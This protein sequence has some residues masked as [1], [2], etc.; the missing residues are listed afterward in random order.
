[1]NAETPIVRPER[2]HVDDVIH[3]LDSGRFEQ[4]QRI[5]TVMARSPLT[6]D[7]LVA[8]VEGFGRDRKVIPLEWD[9]RLA[10]CFLVVNQAVRWG[11]DPFAVAQCCSVVHGKLMFEGKLVAAVLT[12]KL[13]H[14]LAYRWNDATGDAFGIR[15]IGTPDRLGEERI[16]DG[17]VGQWKTSG[18]N[19]PWSK[20]ADHRR[21]LV[22]RGTRDWVRLFEPA[23]LLGVYTPDE[24][25]DL[26]ERASGGAAA[27][28]SEPPR[29]VRSRAKAADA[30]L[31]LAHQP[32]TPV[33]SAAS[34][35]SAETVP[36]GNQAPA[37]AAQKP[38]AQQ[39]N[40]QTE[41][42][43]ANAREYEAV[44]VA[45]EKAA[46]EATTRQELEAAEELTAVY[47]DNNLFGLALRNRI[48]GA[49]EEADALITK[50]EKAEALAKNAKA[51]AGE[52]PSGI[53]TTH[54]AYLRGFEDRK[55]N[56]T[57]CL[58]PEFK[59]DPASFALWEAGHAAASRELAAA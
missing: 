14:I 37:P 12:A 40:G 47:I 18:N 16:L 9:Q 58:K 32:V 21:Q 46:G 6:P 28:A 27:P 44:V 25:E 43:L 54:P 53:D 17:T 19:S 22:Y 2:I 57:R 52:K 36:A 15:V 51:A 48:T 3:V 30:P 39:V 55:R 13:G 24:M 26:Q 10:N 8:T 38:S 1:M 29:Q 33:I 34:E 42:D 41:Q 50:N 20:Q 31:Q 23:I 35:K 11:L 4:M 49:W 7:T 56:I 59:N 5:A 45:F